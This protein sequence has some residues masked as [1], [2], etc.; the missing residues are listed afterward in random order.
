MKTVEIYTKLNCPYCVK[1]KMLLDRKN[2]KYIEIRADLDPSRI[3]EMIE[4]SQGR[5]TFPQIFINDVPIGGC[6]DL[7]ALEQQGQLDKILTN[8]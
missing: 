5:K 3:E 8:A 7:Y 4:K 2:V 1:A 6:D